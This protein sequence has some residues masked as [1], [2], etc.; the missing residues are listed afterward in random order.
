MAQ[1]GIAI[2]PEILVT[3]VGSC[4][5]IILYEPYKD[6]I[7]LVHIMLPNSKNKESKNPLKYADTG[8]K[9]LIQLMRYNQESA[10]KL[11]AKIAGG[12][13]MFGEISKDTPI[14]IGIENIKSVKEIL[15]FYKIPILGEDL[16]GQKGRQILVDSSNK[17]IY[18]NFIGQK[19]R[20]F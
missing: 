17:K 18:V 6:P 9:T 20:E 1:M 12:A 16:G 15:K 10:H 3:T 4:I 19:P 14:Q 2:P 5:A 13:Q 8:I 11:K 7:G